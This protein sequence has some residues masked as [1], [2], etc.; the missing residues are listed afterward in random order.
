MVGR[1]PVVGGE[2]ASTR[3]GKRH[4]AAWRTRRVIARR[5]SGRA[6]V[7]SRPAMRAHGASVGEDLSGVFEDDHSVAE[8]AP[9]L[10]REGRDDACGIVVARV[11]GWTLWLVLAH[12]G[13]SGLGVVTRVARRPT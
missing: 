13:I 10:L 6:G 5:V 2:V 12:R 3:Q 11:S 9:A 8:Q 1:R 7:R 4:R